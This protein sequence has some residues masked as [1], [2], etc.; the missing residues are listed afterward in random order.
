MKQSYYR[1]S[2]ELEKRD[3]ATNRLEKNKENK[4]ML[5]EYKKD[6]FFKTGNEYFF[7]MNSTYKDKNRNICKKEK[8]IKDEIKKELLFVRM[9]LRRCNN[10]VRKHLHKPIGTYINFD[11]ESVQENMID[12]N[13]SMDIIN[14][15]KEY[16]NKLEE[17]Q[18]ELTN[19]LNSIKNK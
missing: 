13:K 5:T 8:I 12:F 15:Y 18:N 3:V 11:D 2:R 1:N 6:I 7:K 19:K 17:Q 4:K 10:K 9:E 14:P 16:I